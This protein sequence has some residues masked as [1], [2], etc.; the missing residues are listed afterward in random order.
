[1]QMR[2]PL[3]QNDR[4]APAARG[5][6]LIEVVTVIGILGILL[7]LLLPAFSRARERAKTLQCLSQLRQI[8]QAIFAYSVEN[9]AQMPA[10]SAVHY[11][12]VDPPYQNMP[13][14]PDYAGPGW[15]VL[16][17]R[18][19]GQNPDGSVYH[20]PA[21]PSETPCVNYFLSARWMYVQDPLLRTMPLSRIR[22]SS[23]FILAGDC[24]AP[25]YYPS[26]FGTATSSDDDID[27]DDGAVKCLVFSGEAGGFNMHRIGNNVLFADGHA[28]TCTG[29]EPTVMTHS[30]HGNE[31]WES[32]ALK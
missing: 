7:A 1:M 5:F 18:Y 20:C 32:L 21:F 24:T 14:S 19:I 17:T 15:P 8:G 27:K 16:L 25:V 26:P 3:A 11:Y 6:T 31:T 2:S 29:F 10:W 9:R 23:R 30:P 4:V 22:T 28:V 13:D 12:P